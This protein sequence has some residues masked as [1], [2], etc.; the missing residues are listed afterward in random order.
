[1]GLAP[2]LLTL[3]QACAVE[4]IEPE[5]IYC[6]GFAGDKGLFVPELNASALSTLKQQIPPDCHSGYS[7]S[8]TSE[9]GLSHHAGI[10]YRSLL[11]L[12]DSVSQARQ[13]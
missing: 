1:M 5:H 12:L 6:C 4:V 11:F 8:R 3:A 9:I 10:P 13:A 7:N 2:Y